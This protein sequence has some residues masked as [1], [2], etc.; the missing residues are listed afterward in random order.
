[1][2]RNILPIRYFV[3]ALMAVLVWGLM[4]DPAQ[5]AG[6][7]MPW[8]APLQAIV[9]SING[10][11]AQFIGIIAVTLTGLTMAMGDSGGTVQRLL[12]IVFGLSI[13]F[14]ATSF[15]LGFFSFGGGAVI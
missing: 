11:V 12:K 8:E 3:N 15:F 4:S 1:M 9:D 7:G 2:I 6:S 10:P 5:A 14:T 13:A